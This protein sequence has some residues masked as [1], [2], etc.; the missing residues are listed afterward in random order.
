MWDSVS[1]TVGEYY[2][3]YTSYGA[4]RWNNMSPMEYGTVLV[5]IAMMGWFLMKNA[6]R[7]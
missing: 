4:R 5:M 1:S 2:H 3:F 6:A 7:R